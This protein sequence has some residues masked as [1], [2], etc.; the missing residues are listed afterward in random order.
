MNKKREYDEWLKR[1]NGQ[2]NYVN[3][4]DVLLLQC[5]FGL[6]SFF[7]M[8]HAREYENACSNYTR[9]VYNRYGHKQ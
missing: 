2:D 5:G 6:L 8:R 3:C 4:N 1:R 9:V 7:V